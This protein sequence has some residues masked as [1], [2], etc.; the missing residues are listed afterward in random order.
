MTEM[1][2]TPVL[3]CQIPATVT[4]PPAVSVVIP[5][6]N[7]AANV[8]PLVDALTRAL[9]GIRTEVLFV[10]DSDDDTSS[11]IRDVAMVWTN[12][13]FEIRLLQRIGHQRTGGLSG[14]VLE[15]IAAARSQW[16]CVMDGDL[17]HPPEVIVELLTAAADGDAG[18]VIA[19]RYQPTGSNAGL[20]GRGRKLVSNLS[21]RA[22]HLAFARRL[23]DVSDPMT[24]FFL[25]DRT[26]LDLGR[27][28]PRGFK[29]L[30][31]IMVSHPELRTIERPFAFGPRHAGDSKANAS[32]GFEFA[33]QLLALRLHPSGRRTW[34]YD[35]HGLVGIESDRVLPELER[36]LVP[37]LE[38]PAAIR[39]RVEKLNKHLP[40]GES[41]NLTAETPRVSYRERT[42][43]AMSLE[44]TPARV[45]VSV[46]PFVARSPHVLYTNV[47]EPI[48][49]WRLVELGY[50]L[51]HAAC[52][53]DADD[54]FLVTA[55]TDTGK[56]TT[57]LKILDG[58]S[59]RFVS[60]DLVIMSPDGIVRSFPKP[61]TISA[62]TVQALRETDL[63]TRE[64][65]ALVP[66]SRVHSR[67]GRRLAFWMTR[68]RL[69]VASI[70]TI[71]QRVVPP[72]KYH[73]QRLV[74]GVQSAGE[75]NVA[76]M[77]VI[78][79]G[80]GGDEPLAPDESLTILLSNCD[81]AFGFPPYASLERLLLAVADQDLRAEERRIVASAL[82]GVKARRMR[83]DSLDWAR[84]IPDVLASWRGAD[85]A[86]RAQT[87]AR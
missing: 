28:R 87:A 29:I 60:D 15:G 10:D 13:D 57:M 47:V 40:S 19:S 73:V 74:R 43:F 26:R 80:G 78:E 34:T 31:E 67:E 1:L 7:E 33:R 4:G 46:S 39:L 2:E 70:N 53:A 16:V 61:L 14:A 44:V 38:M 64:R 81:D 68:Y 75:A 55:R 37:S 56:T 48:L 42:G 22:A 35:V 65:L 6:K 8:E 63:K 72:P 24:G 45:S 27:L 21:S 52:F 85:A 76:G 58:S 71:V 83:S 32:Q 11:R 62:H 20:A 54:A 3:G 84:R 18:L 51:V 77:F 82:D 66:Q 17:Q 69:P 49:R 23:A 5:T 36:F 50:A 59:L 86:E 41:I 30:L 9:D 12:P 25:V 79:R